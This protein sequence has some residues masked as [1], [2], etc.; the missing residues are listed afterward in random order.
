MKAGVW[1]RFSL[2]GQAGVRATIFFDGAALDFGR[3][4]CDGEAR[5]WAA[6]YII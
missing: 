1:A 3:I 6:F 4:V 5:V 2:M